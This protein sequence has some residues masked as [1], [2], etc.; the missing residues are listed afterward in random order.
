MSSKWRVR[1]PNI[2]PV[3]FTDLTIEALSNH[4]EV[5]LSL[6]PTRAAARAAADRFREW[7]FCLRNGS[8]A[9]RAYLIE[10]NYNIKLITKFFNHKYELWISVSEKLLSVAERLNPDLAEIIAL[11]NARG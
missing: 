8:F 4:E 6:H 9:H 11:E 10:Q 3:R 1:D 7:R 5:F 2:F